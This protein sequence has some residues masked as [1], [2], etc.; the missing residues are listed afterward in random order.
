MSS[1][2]KA[3]AD[4]LRMS[5]INKKLHLENHVLFHRLPDE[6]LAKSGGAGGCDPASVWLPVG[7]LQA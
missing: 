5:S 3:T 7:A 2:A 6:A 4:R 1:Y